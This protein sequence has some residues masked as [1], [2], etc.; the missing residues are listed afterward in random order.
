M[1]KLELMATVAVFMTV[2]FYISFYEYRK[3]NK[4]DA[5]F[6]IFLTAITSAALA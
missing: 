1:G 6:A 4:R 5:K 2:F 3:D